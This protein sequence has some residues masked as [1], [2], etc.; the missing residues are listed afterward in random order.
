MS[1]EDIYVMPD[2]DVSWCVVLGTLVG[3]SV[4]S[5]MLLKLLIMFEINIPLWASVVTLLFEYLMLQK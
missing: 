3:A 2:D 5:V 4:F 1:V